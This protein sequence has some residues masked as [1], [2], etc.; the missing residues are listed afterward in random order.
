VMMCM[1]LVRSVLTKCFFWGLL[2]SDFN[3]LA[4]FSSFICL[5]ISFSCTLKEQSYVLFMLRNHCIGRVVLTYPSIHTQ[6]KLSN[7]INFDTLKKIHA[8]ENPISEKLTLK[9]N[10]GNNTKSRMK[11]MD[12]V[13][14]EF[15][16]QQRTCT[17]L[18]QNNKH[19]LFMQ[20]QFCGR[21]L[22]WR[23]NLLCTLRGGKQIKASNR[24]F[25]FLCIYILVYF[26]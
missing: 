15:H 1:H 17:V 3:E 10:N 23:T 22:L 6:L 20:W 21:C 9:C 16:V 25:A 24:S 4:A 5:N 7:L 14:F 26:L 19:Q 2:N 18:F 8:F 12:N 13:I 11:I